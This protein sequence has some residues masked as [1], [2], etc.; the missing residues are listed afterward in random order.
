MSSLY[1]ESYQSLLDLQKS[2]YERLEK[3]ISSKQLYQVYKYFDNI[4]E[5]IL[6]SAVSSK[7]H[8]HGFNF[9][10]ESH[11]AER[12]K[13]V[14]KMSD[15]RFGLKDTNMNYNFYDT[16][17]SD[18]SYWNETQIRTSTFSGLDNTFVAGE[19]IKRYSRSGSWKL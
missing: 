5:E 8:Y 16:R 6:V 19:S 7:V 17:I 4:L 2:F 13:Y 15:S 11:I 18:A 14:Y 9:V 12:H 1:E 10:F 3:Q